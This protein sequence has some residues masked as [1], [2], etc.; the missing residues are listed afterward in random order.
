MPGPVVR[1]G[2]ETYVLARNYELELTYTKV[3]GWRLW[4]H[5]IHTPQESQLLGGEF[6][7]PGLS[8]EIGG[9]VVLNNDGTAP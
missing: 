2:E 9:R 1:I 3:A 8:I 7:E 5:P 6:D 4:R